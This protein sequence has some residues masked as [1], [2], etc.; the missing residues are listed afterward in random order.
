MSKFTRRRFLGSTAAGMASLGVLGTNAAA[1][2]PAPPSAPV[3]SGSAAQGRLRVQYT[4]GGHTVPIPGY[5]MFASDLFNDC[6]VTVFPRPN[7]FRTLEDP[8][9]RPDV[10]VLYDYITTEWDAGDKATIQKYLDDGKGIVI[11]HHAIAANQHWPWWY[12][13][14]TGGEL[15]Q[16]GVPGVKRSRLKQFPVQR[17]TPVGDHPIVRGLKPFVFPRDEVFVDMWVS[18][19]ITPLL[20]SDDPDLGSNNTIAW[21]GVHPTGKIAFYQSGHTPWACASPDYQEI[22][23][24]MV[25]WAGGRLA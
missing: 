25:L 21:V 24:R 6:D 12:R 17:I 15:I 13:E 7:S 3:Q 22:V 19:R 18:P 23:H 8:A 14:A 16:L 11:L 9:T 4:T 5:A 20:K 1:A 2:Q 10:L